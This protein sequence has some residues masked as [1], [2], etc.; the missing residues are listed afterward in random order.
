MKSLYTSGISY[1][2]YKN[3]LENFVKIKKSLKKIE[4]FFFK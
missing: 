1:F 3:I 4:R 2:L